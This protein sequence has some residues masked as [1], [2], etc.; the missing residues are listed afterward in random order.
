LTTRRSRTQQRWTRNV[1]VT[2]QVMKSLPARPPKNPEPAR[3]TGSAMHLG[4][5]ESCYEV[6][7]GYG[8]ERAIVTP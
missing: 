2:P 1:T 6:A 3:D 4:P 5:Y 8:F 7:L